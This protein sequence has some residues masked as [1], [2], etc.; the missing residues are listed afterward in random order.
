[1]AMDPVKIPQNVYIED[2]IV[3]PLTLKQTMLIT[4]GGGLSYMI[5]AMLQKNMNGNPGVFYSILAWTPCFISVLFA[6]VKVN[7]LSLMRI[8][9]LTIERINKAPVRTFGPRSGITIN[10]RFS[11]PKLEDPKTQK[12]RAEDERTAHRIEELSTIIDRPLDAIIT[13]PT[14]EDLAATEAA[15]RL[16]TTQGAPA[17]GAPLDGIASASVEAAAFQNPLAQPKAPPAAA[18]GGLPGASFSDLSVFRDVFS[19]KQQP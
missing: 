14:A 15:A 19:P 4:L 18:Q 16:A 1:M 8:V 2:R 9:L 11:G 13:A 7:D 12:T 17:A 6:L 10:V 3:G 5:F